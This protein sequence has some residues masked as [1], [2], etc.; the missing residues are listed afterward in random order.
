MSKVLVAV[1]S[2]VIVVAFIAVVAVEAH[3]EHAQNTRRANQTVLEACG[4]KRQAV[5]ATAT[6]GWS[7]GEKRDEAVRWARNCL[8][9]RDR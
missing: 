1:V 3:H 9:G 6:A 4:S 5:F 7:S 2:A 8:T